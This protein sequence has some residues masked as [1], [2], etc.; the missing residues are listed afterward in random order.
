MSNP[1][2]RRTRLAAV[3]GLISIVAG[4]F[5]A[6]VVGA[7]AASAAYTTACSGATDSHFTDHPG[8]AANCMFDYVIALGK[9]NGTFGENDD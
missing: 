5:V 2:P 9:A 3:V 1:R 7:P 6:G 4:L 8:T